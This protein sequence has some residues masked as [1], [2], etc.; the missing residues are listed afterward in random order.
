M[1]TILQT[2]IWWL[3]HTTII[4][5]KIQFPMHARSFEKA[6]KTK[7][8][9]LICVVVG[10]VL[11]LAPVVAAMAD[12]GVNHDSDP[13]LQGKNV[14][15]LSGGLGYGQIRFPPVLC[16]GTNSDAVYYSSILPINVFVIIGLT[17]LIFIFRTIY[18]VT[19]IALCTPLN[20]KHR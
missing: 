4:F 2:A 14:T 18:K 1:Y 7:Y 6:N 3:F 13:L 20:S 5:W 15:F 10:L 11:P 19:C 12:F 16:A 17:E 9:H 8:L